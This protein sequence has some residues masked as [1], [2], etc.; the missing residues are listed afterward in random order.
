MFLNR[1]VK[2]ALFSN[3][4]YMKRV[5]SVNG[6]YAKGVVFLPRI[7]PFYMITKPNVQVGRINVEITKKIS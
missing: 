1:F 6:R 5:L 2:R 3:E 4:R 7:C